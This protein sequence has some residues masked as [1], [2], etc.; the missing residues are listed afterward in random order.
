MNTARAANRTIEVGGVGR[1]AGDDRQR[2]IVVERRKPGDRR[3]SAPADREEVDHVGDDRGER[4]GG[5]RRH[6]AAR[7]AWR[8]AGA[9]PARQAAERRRGCPAG[10]AARRATA[11]REPPAPKTA[12]PSDV[13]AAISPRRR[14]RRGERQQQRPRHQPV[15]RH[16]PRQL[17]IDQARFHFVRGLGRQVHRHD[18]RP[19][20]TRRGGSSR[21]RRC[22]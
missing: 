11:G 8:R 19:G 5:E 18:P 22:P 14:C 15:A 10:A 1:V 21:T 20:C 16:R 3:A 12:P 2:R 17:E 13:P 9:K 7:A 6:P 4:G